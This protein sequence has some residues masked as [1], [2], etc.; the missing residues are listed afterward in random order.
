MGGY[1]QVDGEGKIDHHFRIHLEQGLAGSGQRLFLQGV[2]SVPIMGCSVLKS[3][4]SVK[5]Q[6]GKK[7]PTGKPEVKQRQP[8]PLSFLHGL[9][10]RDLVT[11][12]AHFFN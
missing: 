10:A 1:M 2:I 4:P 8:S 6:A 11:K 3:S 7:D 9:R 5:R 12:A